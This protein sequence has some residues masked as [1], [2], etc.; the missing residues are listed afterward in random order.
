MSTKTKDDVIR[1]I[2]Q[3]TWEGVNISDKRTSVLG[4]WL[5]DAAMFRA[6]QTD[7][8]TYLERYTPKA[9]HYIEAF[10]DTKAN[11]YFPKDVENRIDLLNRLTKSIYEGTVDVVL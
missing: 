6:W 4:I 1:G 2:T 3:F 8:L 5:V 7:V 11:D 9:I 10:K